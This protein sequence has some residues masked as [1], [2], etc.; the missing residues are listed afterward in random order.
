LN[1][2]G[3]FLNLALDYTLN[4]FIMARTG[5]RHMGHLLTELL[6]HPWHKH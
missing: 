5:A 6:V 3:G 1:D 2:E 4:T